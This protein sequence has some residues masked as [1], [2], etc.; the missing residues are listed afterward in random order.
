MITERKNKFNEGDRVFA[1]IKG[2]P[3]WPAIVEKVD[4]SSN[5]PKYEV[6][7]YGDKI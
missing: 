1:K 5:I 7:F 4:L 2:F 6:I 3:Y